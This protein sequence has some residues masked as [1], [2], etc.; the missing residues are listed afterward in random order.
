MRLCDAD[1]LA[2]VSVSHLR[3]DRLEIG[4]ALVQLLAKQVLIRH[5]HVSNTTRR[6]SSFRIPAYAKSGGRKSRCTL[7]NQKEV[8]GL[9]A[10]RRVG[11][12]KN[13]AE[14]AYR[15]VG[16]PHLGSSNPPSLPVFYRPRLRCGKSEPDWSSVKQMWRPSRL[17]S[18]DKDSA[19]LWR[20]CRTC[21]QTQCP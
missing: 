2:A 15:T 11:R 14:I 19:P 5:P 18:P 3:E 10:L 21:I 12:C 9:K 20:R 13:G 7:F 1:R 4:R 6:L 17:S 16:N 8:E